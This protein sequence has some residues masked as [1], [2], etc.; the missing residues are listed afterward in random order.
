[1]SNLNPVTPQASV[2][3]DI[4]DR[5]SDDTSSAF[6]KYNVHQHNSVVLP[7]FTAY[8]IEIGDSIYLYNNQGIDVFPLDQPAEVVNITEQQILL[9]QPNQLEAVDNAV[10]YY[11]A[12]LGDLNSK[13]MAGV[14]IDYLSDRLYFSSTASYYDFNQ[15]ARVGRSGFIDQ[16]QAAAFQNDIISS[17]LTIAESGPKV[18]LPFVGQQAWLIGVSIYTY[19]F[20]GT[21]AFVGYFPEDPNHAQG[22]FSTWK[23]LTPLLGLASFTRYYQT[24]LETILSD[25]ATYLSASVPQRPLKPLDM[26]GVRI[27]SVAT[28]GDIQIA[29]HFKKVLN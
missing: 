3:L 9:S 5:I 8:D 6:L 17:N 26:L 12:P 14:S 20:V 22:D 24:C 23:P 19:D 29:L 2:S 28:P 13:S 27:L 4:Y 21:V 11:R 15:Q 10:L 25:D 1:L 7:S 16:L 18:L